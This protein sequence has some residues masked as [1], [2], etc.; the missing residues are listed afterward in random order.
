MNDYIIEDWLTRERYGVVQTTNE[1]IIRERW[2][3]VYFALHNGMFCDVV[4]RKLRSA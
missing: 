4:L 1:F 3:M 2:E